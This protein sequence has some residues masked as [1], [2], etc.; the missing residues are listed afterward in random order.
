METQDLLDWGSKH[1]P[2]PAVL[3]L[4]MKPQKEEVILYDYQEEALTK[5]IDWFRAGEQ[6]ALIALTVGLGKTI[7]ASACVSHALNLGK[8]VLWLT[9]RDE[10]ITQSAA[11]LERGTG[12][13]CS[14]EKAERKASQT[15]KIIVASIQSLKGV[16]LEKLATWFEPDLIVCDEA[17]HALAQTWMAVKTTFFDSKVLNLTATPYRSDVSTRLNL[18]TVLIEKN[19]TDGIKM[20]KL[21][22]PKPVGKIEIDLGKVK[23]ALGDYEVGALS[24]VLCKPQIIK[25][26]I[27][28][29]LK[30]LPGRR[31]IVFAA[32]VEHGTL[33]ATALRD[34]NIECGEVYGT[35]PTEERKRIF[36]KA[37]STPNYLIINNLVL[38]EG[39]NLPALDLVAIFRP[40]KN[41]ALYLQMLGRGLRVCKLT[42]KKECLLIDVIDTAK[43]KTAEGGYIL[44][45]EEDKRKYSALTGRGESIG[46]TFF[47][48]F[49]HKDNVVDV[50]KGEKTIPQCSHLHSGEQVYSLFFTKPLTGWRTYQQKVIEKLAAIFEN[51]G[52]D[53]EDPTDMARIF[54]AI[55]CGNVDS[56]VH[57]SAKSGWRYF[58]HQ[59]FPEN[60]KLLEE[61]EEA[62]ELKLGDTETEKAFNFQALISE[63][64][65]LKNFIMDIFG[66]DVNL[67]DQAKKYYDLH[68][69]DG[70]PIVW[71]RPFQIT[72]AEFNYIQPRKGL[73]WVRTEDATH[74]VFS[75]GGGF[76]TERP[77][78][79]MQLTDVPIYNQ[80]TQWAN[81]PITEKQ[82]I[83]VA[84]ILKMDLEEVQEAH[85]SRL[86]ASAV[87][88]SAWAK[89]YLAKIATWLKKNHSA[90]PNLPT[91]IET[92]PATLATDKDDKITSVEV[93]G[94]K[95]KKTTITT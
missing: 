5:F 18:G 8:K 13:F 4:K 89:R 23:K 90:T 59:H 74:Y 50:I 70:V 91:I 46:S 81:D 94:R 29:L 7:T 22:P 30:H 3:D 54:Q 24:K 14:I 71:Y 84:K 66:D 31:G 20:G 61:Q 27:D 6:E 92:P 17:H 69:I 79:K 67:G 35:T 62:L 52:K 37:K 10:L 64:A 93:Q 12:E 51:P 56:F 21:V 19:T 41:A 28:L 32:S 40:T 82:A 85:I 76:I 38:T 49:F 60:L 47:S 65:E 33:L 53:P 44:P 75:A 63:D 68:R 43:R 77:N 45:S 57:L 78:F 36:A 83:Q 2:N 95:F 55:R 72:N 1:N 26:G 16:R 15:A 88:S 34:A 73:F 86:S 9:H 39:F 87:M 58:P 11:D 25:A 42:N 48:W 80:S